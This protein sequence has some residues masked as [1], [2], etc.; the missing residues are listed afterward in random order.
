[1]R[2]G[3]GY[4]K[5]GYE[6]L[7][8]KNLGMKKPEYENA[9]YEMKRNQI[10]VKKYQILCHDGGMVWFDLYPLLY[11]R[12]NQSVYALI[13]RKIVL[14]IMSFSHDAFSVIYQCN[15]FCFGIYLSRH[16]F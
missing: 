7:G 3:L 15:L 8:M 10:G 12:F 11:D 14:T 2:G 6:K 5:F 4:E 9:G 16:F 1:M 13:S